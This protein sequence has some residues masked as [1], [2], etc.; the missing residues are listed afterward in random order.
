[1]SPMDYAQGKELLKLICDLEPVRRDDVCFMLTHRYDMK[2][3]SELVEYVAKKFP[4]IPYVTRKKGGG[5]P[6]GPNAMFSDSYQHAVEL[7]RSGMA[8]TGVMFME[9]DCIPLKKDWLNE[10]IAEWKECLSRGKYI[11]GPWLEDGDAGRAHINGNCIISPLFWRKHRGI[12]NAP[13]NYAWDAY[14]ATAMMS[15]AMPS[16]LIFSDYR[17]GTTD[18]PWRGDEYLWESRGYGMPTNPLYGEKLYP[19]YLHGVKVMDGIYA[20]RRKLLTK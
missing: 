3:D 10:L 17:L 7:N 12:F 14:H 9:C 8:F 11:L 16:R 18:N 6:A 13:A 4:V 2:V 19:S 5:W 1:M 20:V 15:N